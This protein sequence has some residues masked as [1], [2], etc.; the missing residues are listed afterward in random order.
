MEFRDLLVRRGHRPPD[1]PQG[2][3]LP[4]QA[5]PGATGMIRGGCRV[6]LR[7]FLLPE[8]GELFGEVGGGDGRGRVV[9]PGR[10]V[11]GVVLGRVEQPGQE[12]VPP[13]IGARRGRP[14]VGVERGREVVRG[15]ERVRPGDPDAVAR[16]DQVAAPPQPPGVDL[17]GR[18]AG[19]D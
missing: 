13:R 16:R 3:H 11:Q 14:R 10:R 9:Q 2:R 12:L 7:L 15:G 19:A 18:R 4:V 5:A 8:L 6:S 17:Q 1:G